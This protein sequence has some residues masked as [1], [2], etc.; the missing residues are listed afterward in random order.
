M[1][2]A[3][4]RTM[5]TGAVVL[6]AMARLPLALLLI[7]AVYIGVENWGALRESIAGREAVRTF[8]F[9]GKLIHAMQRERG[10]T[11]QQLAHM[12]PQPSSEL[13][14]ARNDTDALLGRFPDITAASTRDSDEF[15]AGLADLRQAVDARS[16]TEADAITR[17]SDLIGVVFR[18]SAPTRSAGE[19]DR[20]IMSLSI[21]R[22]LKEA[23]GQERAV[24]AWAFESGGL[25]ERQRSVWSGLHE[26]QRFLRRALDAFAPHEIQ[27]GVAA[28]LPAHRAAEIERMRAQV[29]QPRSL[30]MPP[31][32]TSETWIRLLTRVI[33]DLDRADA[34]F[35]LRLEREADAAALRSGLILAAVILAAASALAL[36]VRYRLRVSRAEGLLEQ[37]LDNIDEGFALWDHR[38][39]L[40]IWNRRFVELCSVAAGPRR[41]LI[42]SEI[43]PGT[44]FLNLM[45][46]IADSAG[47]Q[48]TE[49]WLE[50]RAETHREAGGRDEVEFGAGNWLRVTERRL[51]CCGT[52]GVYV[53]VSDLYAL[54]AELRATDTRLQKLHRAVEQS[55]VSVVITDPNTVIEYVN[56]AFSKTT[57]YRPEEAI[58]QTPRIL[59]SGQVPASTYQEMWRTLRAGRNWSGE[60]VNLDKFGNA[61]VEE[62]VISPVTGDDGAVVNF[63]AIKL[64]VTKLRNL[65]QAAEEASHAKSRFIANMSH[66]LRTPLNAIVGFSDIM[67]NQVFGPLGNPK[68]SEYARDINAA[69]AHLLGLIN[70]ILDISRIEAGRMELFPETVDLVEVIESA[71]RLVSGRAKQGGVAISFQQCGPVWATVDKLRIKQAALNVIGNAVKFSHAGDCVTVRLRRETE[72]IWIEVL[73]TGIGMTPQE[74]ATALQ[75]FRQVS[76]DLGRRFEGVGLGLPLTKTLVEMHGGRFEIISEKGIGT[77]VRLALPA[78]ARVADREPAEM[79]TP[80]G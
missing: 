43:R 29:E 20:W 71:L 34:T 41:D 69:G 72:E 13:I 44:E 46:V 37:A 4:P 9:A 16:I 26:S 6:R 14:A 39:R 1:R 54:T 42:T 77:L 52:V 8:T 30:G 21:L 38:D 51:P 3:G 76:D 48:D 10:R 24:G 75:P 47:I 15:L 49:R 19:A 23:L 31:T 17:Y 78:P 2:I 58:G 61:F 62:A 27:M 25:V 64:D 40:T 22:Q 12:A 7:F 53:D 45:T 68:Y 70:D 67:C 79:C 80:A 65:Q 57:G 66:E 36:I 63:V 56:P 28:A 5:L 18:L 35:T 74:L 55:P 11:A 33:D 73:D 59:K 50:R 60:L 32:M